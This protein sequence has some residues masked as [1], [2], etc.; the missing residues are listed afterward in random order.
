MA[1]Q[2]GGEQL[3]SVGR[4]QTP[5]L[6]MIIERDRSIDDFKPEDF[7]RVS[8]QFEA[9]EAQWQGRW[10]RPQSS[11]GETFQKEEMRR[12]EHAPPC[13]AFFAKAS[14]SSFCLVIINDYK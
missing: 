4:V 9:Q 13:A 14:L 12:H 6:A 11:S 10:F 3:L 5:T 8:A 2:A 7:W 1:R